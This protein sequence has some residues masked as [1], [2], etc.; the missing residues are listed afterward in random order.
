MTEGWIK[1]HRSITEK[2]WFCK[3]DYVQLW[4]HLLVMANF[5]DSEYLWNG[6][7]IILKRGQ[8]ITGRKSLSSKTGISESKIQRILKC[9]ENEHQIEQ[10]TTSTSRLI[11]ILNYEKYQSSEQPFEQQ[12]NNERTTDEQRVNTKEES[13]NN[14]NIS[15]KD[16][17][18]NN[19]GD[20]DYKGKGEPEV[21][22]SIPSPV[23]TTL[24]L[25]SAQNASKFFQQSLQD[26]GW[27]ETLMRTCKITNPVFWITEFNDHS[28][29]TGEHYNLLSDY[30]RHCVNWI[31]K[32][33]KEIEKQKK[34]GSGKQTADDRI[35]AYQDY[36]ANA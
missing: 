15:N 4:I 25:D 36:I 7:V 35:R 8:L 31:K 24:F 2:G 21:I 22:P 29:A 6:K 32:E 27:Q 19:K 20:R 5:K 17:L 12:M 18:L 3:P 16:N 30:R 33:I 23:Q 28:I 9:F 14:K 34:N 11:S 10:Q 26:D 13:N 1:I